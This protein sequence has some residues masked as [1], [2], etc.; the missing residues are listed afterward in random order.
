MPIN[1]AVLGA[2]G[3]VGQKLIA[4]LDTHPDFSIQELVASDGNVGKSYASACRWLEP[5]CD[6]PDHIG[7]MKISCSRNIESKVIVSCL[8]SSVADEIEKY[9]LD[10]GKIIFSNASTHRMQENVPL[11]IPEVNA[12]HYAMLEQQ[13]FK[14]KIIT[15]PN[16]SVCG[17]AL[18]L[19]PLYNLGY[20]D[21]VSIVTLQSVSG[22]GFRGVSVLDILGNTIPDIDGEEEKIVAE[23]SKIFADKTLHKATQFSVNVHRVPVM[24]GHVAT[25]HVTFTSPISLKHAMDCYTERNKKFANL[26]SLYQKRTEPQGSRVLT[27]DDMRLHIGPILYGAGEHILKIVVLSHNLVR[28]AAGAIIANM[29]HYFSKELQP[30]LC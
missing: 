19:D 15:N 5:L 27:H 22:A 1:V 12:S 10:K 24:Y 11:V 26:Y 20:I 23:L 4:L 13:S 29:E 9:Y 18:A 3:L 2:T 30:S 6:L 25:L 28:G 21:H 7:R 16:C 17:I 8:P 14:G